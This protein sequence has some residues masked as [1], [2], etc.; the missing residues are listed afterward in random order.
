MKCSG[1]KSAARFAC[2]SLA[3][4]LVGC[5]NRGMKADTGVEDRGS[6]GDDRAVAD[7]ADAGMDAMAD[8][9]PAVDAPPDLSPPPDAPADV[10]PDVPAGDARDAAPDGPRDTGRGD[11]GCPARFNFENG[12]TYMARNNNTCA[13]CPKGFTAVV[14]SGAKTF[15]GNGALEVTAAFVA[16]PT[17]PTMGEVIIPLNG[18]GED[19]TGKMLTVSVAAVPSGGTDLVLKVVLG[20]SAGFQTALTFSSVSDTFATQS[21]VLSPGDGGLAGLGSVSQISLQATSTMGYAGK[22][23]V[24]ELDIR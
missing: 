17:G 15:C 14:N 19:L 8:D 1:M 3:L 2:L 9:A 4:T 21:I 13:S 11:A 7:A 20:T 6:M 22:I 12:A 23:Y 16:P 18:A 5:A 10:T 24:D